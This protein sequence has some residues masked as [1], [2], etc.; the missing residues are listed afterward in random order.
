MMNWIWAVVLIGL[1]VLLFFTVRDGVMVGCG[2]KGVWV[3]V[4]LGPMGYR[5][6]PRKT[7]PVKEAKKQAR[8]EKKKRKAEQKA[9]EKG[10]PSQ[11]GP[12]AKEVLE[13]LKPLRPVLFQ[14]L[15]RFQQKLRIDQ[16]FLRLAWGEDDPADAAIHYGYA[17]GVAE[18][19]LA[20]LQANFIVKKHQMDVTLDYTLDKPKLY[21]WARLSLTLA[22]LVWIVLPVGTRGLKL[23]WNR[24]KTDRPSTAGMKGELNH[25]KQSTSQRTD[26]RDHPEDP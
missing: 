15:G 11:T 23:M 5:I 24:R 6:Y 9:K 17:W 22:Q 7:D 4:R 10:L 12:N 1:I 2:A 26:D 25:G 3:D 20:V 18:S 13:L 19:V 16:L 8:K 14:A 21:L